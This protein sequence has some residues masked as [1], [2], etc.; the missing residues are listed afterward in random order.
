MQTQEPLVR[1]SARRFI[2]HEDAWIQHRVSWLLASTTFLIGAFAVLMTANIPTGDPRFAPVASLLVCLPLAG[3]T[4]SSLVLLG[5]IPAQLAMCQAKRSAEPGQDTS[6]DSHR[7]LPVRS[8][9][10]ALWLGI[11]SSCGT[12]LATMLIWALLLLVAV[13]T[14]ILTTVPAA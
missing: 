11:L 4:F 8:K 14:V 9:G 10:P 7:S 1:K 13:I 6:H 3:L 5:Y 12:I 2:E